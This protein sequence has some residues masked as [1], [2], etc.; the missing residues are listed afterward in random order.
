MSLLETVQ[1][2][3][4][5]G[6]IHLRLS[7]RGGSRRERGAGLGFTWS[8]GWRL[9]VDGVAHSRLPKNRREHHGA[10]WRAA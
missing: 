7:P 2:A 4:D 3:D 9:G 5:D 1:R 10:V 8:V 6:C